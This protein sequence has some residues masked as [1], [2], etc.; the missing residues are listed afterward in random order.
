MAAQSFDGLHA[1]YFLA[2]Q[3]YPNCCETIFAAEGTALLPSAVK[4]QWRCD[5]CDHQFQTVE[6]IEQ[7]DAAA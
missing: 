3:K 4:Y 6:V 5:L 2:I 1:L 7:E